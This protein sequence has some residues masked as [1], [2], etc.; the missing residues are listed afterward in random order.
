MS[1]VCLDAVT[2][3]RLKPGSQLRW[4]A[5]VQVRPGPLSAQF[6]LRS[7]SGRVRT[8]RLRGRQSLRVTVTSPSRTRPQKC[9]VP[10]KPARTS[11][12]T[13]PLA[14][15]S[16]PQSPLLPSASSRRTTPA[17]SSPARL[18]TSCAASSGGSGNPRCLRTIA[19]STGWK[20]AA[21]TSSFESAI[22]IAV[23][24]PSSKPRGGR[25]RPV[26]AGPR[27]RWSPR[28]LGGRP[29]VQAMRS[30]HRSCSENSVCVR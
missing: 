28:R 7:S 27:H 11:R 2:A 15:R 8:A 18:Q 14:A 6:T 30:N 5:S 24:A 13:A 1:D 26:G 12:A 4:C 21:T 10:S 25:G 17:G 23:L 29:A 22:A 3:Q 16:G 19:A 20:A 9:K